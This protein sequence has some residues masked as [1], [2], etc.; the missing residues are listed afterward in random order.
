MSTIQW[1]LRLPPGLRWRILSPNPNKTSRLQS[2]TCRPFSQTTCAHAKPTKPPKPKVIRPLPKQSRAQPPAPPPPTPSF[3][4]PPPSTNLSNTRPSNS[5]L[6]PSLT[7]L[8]DTTGQVLLYHAPSHTSFYFFSYLFGTAVLAG[9]LLQAS[10]INVPTAAEAQAEGKQMP[11]YLRTASSGVAIFTAAIGTALILAPAKLIRS[12]SLVASSMPGN[13][14]RGTPFLRLETKPAIP[15][16]GRKGRVID[17]PMHQV[18]IDRQVVGMGAISYYHI[19]REEAQKFT[20]LG[21][22]ASEGGSEAVKPTIIQRLQAFN[23][24]LLNIWPNLKQD[25]RRMLLRDGIA[26]VRIE[27]EGGHWKLDVNGAQMLEHGKPLA[28]ALSPGEFDRSWLSK[29]RKVIGI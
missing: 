16:F 24:S 13:L 23:T 15:L 5:R 19:P 9:S 17:A 21:L 11:W 12:V 28:A 27:G 14:T 6:D 29:A 7:Q 25:T 22:P 10:N 3:T 20:Q 4:T 1:L 26:Y 2:L 8:L 18:F